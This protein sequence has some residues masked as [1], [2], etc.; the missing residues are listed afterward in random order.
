MTEDGAYLDYHVRWRA[1]GRR[2]GKHAARAIGQGGDFRGCV[3]FWQ[4]PDATR[5]DV[6]RSIMDPVGGLLVRQMRQRSAIDVVLAVDVSRSMGRLGDVARLAAAAARAALKAG[7]RFGLL[8]FDECVR[9]DLSLPPS[10][11]RGACLE[12]AQA[13]ARCGPSGRSAEGV[14]A[15]SA[16]LPATRCLLVLV[17]DFLVP[18]PVLQAALQGLAT[19]DVAPVVLHRAG[20]AWPGAG[21]ARVRDAETGGIR[22]VWL[23]AAAWRRARAAEE[24]RRA[25]LGRLFA[26]HARPPLH[27]TGRIDIAIVSRHL[28]QG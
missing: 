14:L 25:A 1:G 17:S 23:R 11:L 4:V 28:A 26:E 9:S 6:R 27:V 20:F 15:L 21:L 18:A 22:L 2:P 5:I 8:A 19:H 10:R 16:S 3:P 7:D 24:E 12:A 13:L